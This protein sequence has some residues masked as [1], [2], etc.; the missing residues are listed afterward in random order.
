MTK[1]TIDNKPHE[2]PI[3][4]PIIRNLAFNQAGSFMLFKRSITSIVYTLE[5]MQAKA[6]LSLF[7]S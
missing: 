7:N 2:N 3:I 1:I 4:N 5:C 6:I